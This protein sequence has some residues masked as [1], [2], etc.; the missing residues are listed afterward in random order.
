[1]TLFLP[2]L[3]AMAAGLTLIITGLRLLAPTLNRLFC[4]PEKSNSTRGPDAVRQFA[5]GALACILSL[6]ENTAR[7]FVLSRIDSK[8][9]TPTEATWNFAGIAIGST[10]VAAVL[11][12]LGYAVAIPL[13]PYIVLAFALPFK[14]GFR[15]SRSNRGEGITALGLLLVGNQLLRGS[16]ESLNNSMASGFSLWFVIILAAILPLLF[17]SSIL[18][19]LFVFALAAHGQVQ[20]VAAAIMILMGALAASIDTL[21]RTRRLS[22]Q[23]RQAA[24]FQLVQQLCALTGG[25]SALPVLHAMPELSIPSSLILSGFFFVSQIVGISLCIPLRSSILKISARICATEQPSSENDAWPALQLLDSRLQNMTE[26][27]L[28]LL[29]AGL[30]KM[31]DIDCELLM[32][33]MNHSQ[34][35]S[36]EAV[37]LTRINDRLLQLNLLSDKIDGGLTLTVQHS[38]TLEQAAQIRHLQRVA[39]ELREIATACYKITVLLDRSLRQ[40][41][42]F[43]EESREE[44]FALA[45]QVLDFLRYI[46][47][48]L[49]GKIERPDLALARSMENLID[50]VRNKLR[51]QTR[52]FLEQNQDADIKGELTFIEIIRY[53]ENIGDNCLNIARTVPSM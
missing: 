6:S 17:R 26:C 16:F 30:A 40:G 3:T 34:E 48:Y 44:L 32:L 13:L 49:D 28:T 42:K 53:L 25:L 1:M 41:R 47:D 37:D 38:C 8:Q 18:V 35:L 14:L 27:N 22:I 45:S 43:H 33:V 52:K 11:A 23:A 29:K 21:Y 24:I 19:L 9:L 5:N 7:I 31:A 2:L 36:N 46:Q 51:K 15:S 50:K 20:I 10:L 12:L 39:T 4:H